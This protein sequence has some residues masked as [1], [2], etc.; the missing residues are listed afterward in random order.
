MECNKLVNNIFPLIAKQGGGIKGG[1]F[2]YFSNK[3][4]DLL[5]SLY[6]K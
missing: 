5:R 3:K 4:K 6:N 2:M 1:E